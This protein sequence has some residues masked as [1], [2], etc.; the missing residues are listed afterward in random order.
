MLQGATNSWWTMKW[1][2][3]ISGGYALH[4]Q[5]I[6]LPVVLAVEGPVLGARTMF[7]H[8]HPFETDNE[9]H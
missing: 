6:Y 9:H 1:P 5:R 2:P 4:F 7:I 8:W 3:Q